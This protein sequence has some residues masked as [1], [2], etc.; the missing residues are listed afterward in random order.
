MIK[1]T[2]LILTVTALFSLPACEGTPAIDSSA[3]KAEIKSAV[4]NSIGWAIEKDKELLYS[5]LAQDA[6]FF[7]YHP[8]ENTIIGF[9][10]FQNLVETAFMNEAFKATE[11]E[12]KDLRIKLS[13]LGDAAWYSCRLD[14]FGEFNGQPMGW[15]DARWTGVLEKREGKWIIVQMHFSFSEEQMRASE[16]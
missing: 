1:R 9:E 7:I 5:V 16:G 2:L 13:R 14:D 10:A 12:V 6:D 11:F 3:E 4:E 8:N 15:E